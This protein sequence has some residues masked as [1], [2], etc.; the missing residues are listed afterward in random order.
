MVPNLDKKNFILH[1]QKKFYEKFYMSEILNTKALYEPEYE[2][3][4]SHNKMIYQNTKLKIKNELQEPIMQEKMYTTPK[5]S[6]MINK[7]QVSM[8]CLEN[9]INYKFIWKDIKYYLFRSC[10]ACFEAFFEQSLPSYQ[11]SKGLG[12]S[13]IDS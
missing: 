3:D 12:K 1:E 5:E 7:A 6:T 13:S 11:K 9:V 4:I 8:A 10:K 2:K